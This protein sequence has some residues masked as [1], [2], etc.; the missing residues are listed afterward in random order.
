MGVRVCGFR[1]LGFRVHGPDFLKPCSPEL[2]NHA[3]TG[4]VFYPLQRDTVD[5]I[6]RHYL[7]DP[8]LWE[9]WF[10]LIMGNAGFTSS[11]V[12]LRV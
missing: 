1:G 2:P 10:F 4:T 7:K 3:K 12:W 5:D 9:L 11:T 8:K 6:N